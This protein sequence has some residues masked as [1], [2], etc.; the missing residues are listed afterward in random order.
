MVREGSETGCLPNSRDF[1]G[2][3]ASRY[4]PSPETWISCARRSALRWITTRVVALPMRRSRWSSA[5]RSK[6]ANSAGCVIDVIRCCRIARDRRIGGP[7]TSV[8]AYLM[9]HPAQQPPDEFAREQLEKFL[10]GE[11]ER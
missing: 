9:K 5:S 10:A 8:S 6:T 2:G 3:S 1:M 11:I 4:A 7:L